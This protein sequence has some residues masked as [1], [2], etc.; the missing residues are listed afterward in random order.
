MNKPPNTMLVQMEKKKKS[1]EPDS[2][3]WPMD[4]CS[5]TTVHRSTNWAIEGL[6]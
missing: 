1:F 5:T 6:R 3:Q 2:N 4:Y